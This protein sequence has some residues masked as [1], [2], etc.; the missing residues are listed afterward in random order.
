MP[1]IEIADEGL[2][3]VYDGDVPEEYL[4]DLDGIRLSMLSAIRDQETA[5]ARELQHG[6]S[7]VAE[8]T[9]VSLANLYRSTARMEEAIEALGRG[10]VLSSGEGP[11][12]PHDIALRAA[13]L[14]EPEDVLQ[15]KIVPVAEVAANI[16]AWTPP[17]GAELESITTE[18]RA[19]T[20]IS[21][22]QADRLESNPDLDIVKIPGKIVATIKPG[23]RQKCRVVACGNFLQRPKEKRSPTLDRRDIYSAGLDSISLRS[24]IAVAAH[25]RWI[26]ATLDVKTAF[27]TAPYQP[28]RTQS[29]RDKKRIV[30][31]RV[32]RVMILAG[33]VPPGSWIQVEGALY[34]L[35]E[36]P[37]SWGVSRD[38]KLKTLSWLCGGKR[39]SLKQCQSDVSLW[40]IT[41]E[42]VTVGTLGVY[43][44]DLLVMSE[45]GHL[46]AALAA[47]QSLWQTSKPEYIS[48][49]GGLCFCGL[50]ME[51][52]DDVIKIHQRTYLCEL[53]DRYPELVAKA[54]LPDF[55]G[56]PLDEQPCPEAIQ[57]AQRIIGELTWVAGRTRPDIAFHVNRISRMTARYPSQALSLG[58]QVMQYL[59]ATIDFTIATA[60]PQLSLSPCWTSFRLIQRLISFKFGQTHPL[61]KPM[62][63]HKQG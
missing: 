51:Q 38:G 17:L 27:L 50:Q 24:Q 47:L 41:C 20:V 55:R 14:A 8:A 10:D 63:V 62:L 11:P 22:E 52:V 18:H 21:N 12:S 32:P 33:L 58:K 28:P 61:L 53:K 3:R 40:L 35:Q 46:D 36:S 42:A 4:K 1:E 26:G 7:V 57:A 56:E 31:V 30:L 39:V 23:R 25:K 5:L 59:L 16:Q 15:T 45:K 49:K 9:A 37:K 2:L 6:D 60:L 29:K 43:V 13:A 48:Q 44:D 34:G 54:A 19:G